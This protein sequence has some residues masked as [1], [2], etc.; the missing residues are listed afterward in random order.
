MAY[1][2]ISSRAIKVRVPPSLKFPS[3][4]RCIWPLVPPENRETSALTSFLLK[5]A[6]IQVEKERGIRDCGRREWLLATRLGVFTFS[7]QG[8]GSRS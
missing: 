8:R 2:L 3:I 4:L 6:D 1:A 7:F 5:A